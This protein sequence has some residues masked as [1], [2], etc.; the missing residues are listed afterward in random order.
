MRQKELLKMCHGCNDEIRPGAEHWH[1][2][3][4]DS[5]ITITV[6]FHADC[7]TRYKGRKPYDLKWAVHK[8]K[9]N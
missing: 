6:Y 3:L 2:R 5:S 7:Y 9:E 8:P 1:V 4:G